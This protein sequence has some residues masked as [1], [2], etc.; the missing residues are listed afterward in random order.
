MLLGFALGAP[1]TKCACSP[2]TPFSTAKHRRR[3]RPDAETR[4]GL[5]REHASHHVA[6]D[7]CLA[8]LL[9][10]NTKPNRVAQSPGRR[11]QT[12]R[13]TALNAVE[14]PD[15]CVVFH[16]MCGVAQEQHRTPLVAAFT[17]PPRAPAHHHVV[18]VCR[19]RGVEAGACHGHSPVCDSRAN[20]ARSG[21]FARTAK[22]LDGG[23]AAPAEKRHC[24]RS[25][26]DVPPRPRDHDVAICVVAYPSAHMRQFRANACTASAD[27]RACTSAD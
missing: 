12:S 21:A 11:V 15:A 3:L 25:S 14:C 9:P 18:R 23:L 4:Q 16:A 22:L 8:R 5:E 6:G 26:D 17:L 7:L 2:P 13:S 27:R 1:A 24:T 19:Q 10:P 20:H